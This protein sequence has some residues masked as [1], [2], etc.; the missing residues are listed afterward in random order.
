MIKC[1]KEVESVVSCSMVVYY[2]VYRYC[3]FY[4]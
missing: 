4:Y 1:I 2:E 3:L